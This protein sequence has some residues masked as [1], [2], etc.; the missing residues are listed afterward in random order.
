MLAVVA[1]DAS[2]RADGH[3]SRLMDRTTILWAFVVFFG[4]TIAFQAV[5]NATEGESTTVTLAI[6]LVVLVL[7]VGGIILFVRRRER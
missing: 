1:V 4:A 2:G 3:G 5:Q 7:I 6:E